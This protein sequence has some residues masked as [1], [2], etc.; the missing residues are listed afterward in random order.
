MTVS[1]VRME[2]VPIVQEYSDV[3]PDDLPGIPPD[4]EIEFNIDLLPGTTPISIA[5]YRMTPAKFRE[6]KSQLE[7]LLDKGFI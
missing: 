7:E 1:K 5:P 2:D 4:R 6:L 3:F